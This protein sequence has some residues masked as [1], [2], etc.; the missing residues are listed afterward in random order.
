MAE[1]TFLVKQ[2]LRDAK[3]HTGPYSAAVVTTENMTYI[4]TK[5][6][7]PN[8]EAANNAGV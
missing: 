8:I 4:L 7:S 3:I 2:W 6:S 1:N 5:H